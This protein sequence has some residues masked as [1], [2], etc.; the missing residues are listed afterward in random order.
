[1]KRLVVGITGASGSIYGIRLLQEL[2]RRDDVE[3][4]VILSASGKRTLAEE[5]DHSVKEVEALGHFVYDNR[6]VGASLASGS[7]HTG[8]SARGWWNTRSVKP[9]AAYRPTK[10]SKVAAL[11]SGRSAVEPMR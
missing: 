11:A 3:V 4:H 10:S 9:M 7:F 2:R 6:D 8:S 5:T 1:M